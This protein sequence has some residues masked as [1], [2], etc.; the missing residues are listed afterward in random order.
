M[1]LLIEGKKDNSCR[2][3][4]GNWHYWKI[5]KIESNGEIQRSKNET[6]QVD[7]FSIADLLLLA[8]KTEKFMRGEIDRDTWEKSPGLEPIW[9]EWLKYL[10]II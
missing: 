7:F 8:D 3:E 9:H 10:G 2:R 5:Y 4:G 1:Q 6:K